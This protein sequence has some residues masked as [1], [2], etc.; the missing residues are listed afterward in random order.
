MYCGCS[1]EYL[2]AAPAN[3]RVCPVCL[4]LPGAMP[5]INKAAV[6]YT[7]MTGLAL[8]CEIDSFARF[9]RKNYFYPDLMKGYQISQY[10]HPI[11]VH[12]WLEFRIGG[13]TRRV[14]IRRVHL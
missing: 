7:A 10:D 9:D 11:C 1:N 3:S 8:H 13:E 6:E 5:V 4:G 12:G 14:G 2:A